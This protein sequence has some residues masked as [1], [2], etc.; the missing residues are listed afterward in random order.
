MIYENEI[1]GKYIT[2]SSVTLS[3]EDIDFILSIRGDVDKT[4]YLHRID[5]NYDKQKAWVENQQKQPNDYYF[6]I[7]D[8]NGSRIGTIGLSNIDDGV[9]ETSRF[10]S[11]G[12][13][14][15]NVEAN[16][17]IIDFAFYTIGLSKLGGTIVASNSGVISLQKKFGY[18]IS[19]YTYKKDGFEMVDAS[20][21]KEA[22]ANNRKNIEKLLYK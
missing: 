9:G 20:L 6:I 7:R 3:K 17:L 13:A 1:K 15:E 11:Y 22:Y 5:L 12:N 8:L 4:K 2:L 18:S 16:L 14:L 19:N 21:T 10:V